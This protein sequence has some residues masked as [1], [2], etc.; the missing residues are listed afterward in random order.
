MTDLKVLKNKANGQVTIT[1]PKAVAEMFGIDE[2]SKLSLK[3]KPQKAHEFVLRV[4]N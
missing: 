1:I 4:E 3:A 2:S